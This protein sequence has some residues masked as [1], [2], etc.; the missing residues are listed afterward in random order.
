MPTTTPKDGD[1][2]AFEPTLFFFYGTLM[3]PDVLS[4][5]AQLDD[6]PELA[7]AW[8]AGWEM[9]MWS[10]RYPTLVPGEGKIA[11][12]AWRATSRAQC[13]RLQRYETSAY[14]TAPVDIHLE[15]GEVVQGM[16]FKWARGARSRELSDGTFDLAYWQE[17]HK[18][19]M[20]RV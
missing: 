7:P 4:A 19:R 11:G 9:K 5:I 15:S 13:L 14:D 12:R 1:V 17:H 6:T 8:V 3:D 10:G 2:D 20:F 18:S 16:T